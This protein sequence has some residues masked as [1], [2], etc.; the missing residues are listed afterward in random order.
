MD[1]IR[2]L[3][4]LIAFPTVSRDSNLDLIGYVT[5]LLEANGVACQI[6]RSADGHKANLF[7]TIG[8]ADRPGVMLS[9]HTDVVPVDGQNWTLP[10]FEMTKRDGKLYGRGA[11]DM[12]G[13]VASALAACVKASKMALRTPLHLAL[14]YDEEVGCL[15]VRDLIEMLSAAPQRPLLCIVGEPTN[16]QVAT[17]HKGKLAARAICRGREGHSA[18]AP[19]ALNAIHLGCDFVRALRDEQE[20]LARDG[21]RD[22]DYDIPY[23]TVHVGKINAGVALNIVPNLCQVDFEIRN[24]AADNAAG[25]LDRL[26]I[27]AARIAEDAA[28]IA[29]EAAI[30]IEI[31]N[32]YPG[33]DTPAA[34]AAVAFVKSLTGANDTMKVAFGTEGGLFS[35][36]LGTPAVV[37]GP[38]SMAQGHKPDEFV[39]VEQLRGCDGMLDRLLER[40][41]DGW[42]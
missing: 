40:L 7:A 38:G 41:T 17:G 24:V 31:T 5:D 26:R 23:T 27:A 29:A 3:E 32:T 39:S 37:C 8:P 14:S 19:L 28:S 4:R 1:S 30:E 11:T 6:V 20:R 33:L 35:R 36:D 34:S 42:P 13:F 15:G 22:G 10:P 9:G 2:I 12:K 18:L 21:A 16:M 25:I